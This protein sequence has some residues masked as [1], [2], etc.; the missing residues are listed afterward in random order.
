[1]EPLTVTEK[2]NNQYEIV[3]K[4]DF[5]DLSDYIKALATE[6]KNIL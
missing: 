2:K 4:R 6:A 5:S 1:M 3:I